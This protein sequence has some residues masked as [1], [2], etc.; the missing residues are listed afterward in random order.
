MK[1]FV[2]AFMVGLTAA[3]Q[4]AVWVGH[5]GGLRQYSNEGE[6]IREYVGYKR[7]ISLTLDAERRRLW[8]LDAY[9]YKLVCFDADA[10]RETL[11][12]RNA[13]HPPAVGTSGLGIFLREKK[14]FEPSLALDPADGAIWVADFYGHEV[15]KYDR[16]GRELFRSAAFHE[17]FAVAVLDDCYAWV[18]G[19]IRTL[20]L[21]GPQCESRRTMTGV[22]EA[23]DLVYD[24]ARDLVWVADYR[25]NRVFAMDRDGRLK[26]KITGV[27]LPERLAVDGERG[28]VWVAT[29][30]AGIVKISV[31]AEKITATIPEP[32]SATALTLAGDGKLWVAYDET[33]E[34]VCFSPAGDKLLT[35]KRVTRPTGVAAE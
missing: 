18:A 25:N 10:G 3:A 11:S 21:V 13:A 15:A 27:E 30:Y 19:G 7:P 17:P 35:I 2:T 26:R 1:R 22:N 14:P 34:I 16:D 33:E 28:A 31:D 23:R 4:A 32:E 9:D 24:A 8:F 6:L 5:E 29:H 12:V 20:S